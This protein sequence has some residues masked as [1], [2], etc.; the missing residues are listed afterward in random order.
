MRAVYRRI[1]AQKK[2]RGIETF[3]IPRFSRCAGRIG[4]SDPRVMSWSLPATSQ[5][6]EATGGIHRERLDNQRSE[7]G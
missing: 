1:T 5:A 6:I 7:L 4:T 2:T 3:S